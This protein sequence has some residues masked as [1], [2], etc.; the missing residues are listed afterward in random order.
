VSRYTLSSQAAADLRNIWGFI[1]AD[2]IDAADRVLEQ[3]SS[4]FAKLTETPGLGHRR[5][6]LTE[7]DVLFWPVF[8]YLV[9]YRPTTPLR[10]VRVLHSKRNISRIL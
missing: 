2:N 8:S 9:V 5:S 3:L 1:A 10:V 4:Q 6:D 7:R